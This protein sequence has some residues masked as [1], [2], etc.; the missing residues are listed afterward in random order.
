MH[1]TQSAVTPP[2]SNDDLATLKA[3]H[4]RLIRERDRLRDAR[5][6]FSRQL[7]PTPASAG[8]STALV[9]AFG[10][11]P[12]TVF[13]ALALASLFLLVVSGLWYDGKPAYRHLFAKR[14]ACQQ[15]ERNTVDAFMRA[16]HVDMSRVPTP[17]QWYAR[18][19]ELESSIIGELRE[20]N[21]LMWPWQQVDT[22][23]AGVD[24]ERT[25]VRAVQALWL[26]VIVFL[27]LAAT[28]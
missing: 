26:L 21:S 27:V 23:Q 11:H 10:S 5:G 6:S 24:A 28:T 20:H 7:G 16:R 12:K 25:G 18:M 2:A 13:M 1:T 15:S 8:I 17:E 22:L 4:E 19:I 14:L 3:Y 9:A